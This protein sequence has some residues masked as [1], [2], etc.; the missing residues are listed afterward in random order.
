[1]IANYEPGML[2]SRA[3]RLKQIA[4]SCLKLG[5][6]GFGG[7]AGMVSMI[8]NEMVVKRKWI[9]HQHFMD[10][11]STSY[12]IPGPNAVEIIMH[13]GKERVGRLGLV[14]A[15]VCYIFPAILIC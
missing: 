1:M 3:T 2:E 14:V 6:I 12:I 15:G 10:V 8:E 13:C 9:D 5:C 4:F 11:L 7:I